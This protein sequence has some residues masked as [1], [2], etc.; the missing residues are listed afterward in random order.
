MESRT[1]NRCLK[2][3]WGPSPVFRNSLEGRSSVVLGANRLAWSPII[4]PGLRRHHVSAGTSSAGREGASALAMGFVSLVDP[5]HTEACTADSKPI[6][7]LLVAHLRSAPAITGRR[8]QD[9][10]AGCTFGSQRIEAIEPNP[11]PAGW[12]WTNVL[13]S[14]ASAVVRV[15]LAP[16]NLD[17]RLHGC[18][19]MS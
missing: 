10:N 13:S 14:M 15:W 18:G 16:C 7:P 12:F 5:A 6:S 19:T 17:G 3:D 8:S 11:W 2:L 1:P 9:P 4:F